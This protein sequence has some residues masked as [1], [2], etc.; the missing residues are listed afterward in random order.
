MVSL[1]V[2]RTVPLA[3]TSAALPR[4]RPATEARRYPRRMPGG[5]PGAV[6]ATVF[7][8]VLVVDNVRT[9][10]L[11]DPLTLGGLAATTIVTAVQSLLTDD[12]QRVVGT[13][14][15]AAGMFVVVFVA[16][17]VRPGMLGFGTVK[18]S[19]LLGAAAGGLGPAP[20]L[21]G[22]LG[23]AVGCVVLA[24]V[25]RYVMVST[26]PSGP[27]LALGLVTALTVAVVA[28]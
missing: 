11:R 10:R 12:P 26:L 5:W 16:E 20:W 23:F 13:L 1:R 27:A 15:G 2:V 22:L 14:V 28:A 25:W 7:V 24:T 8:L 21:G 3:G 6:V 19:A 9:G 18:S 4:H 17:L